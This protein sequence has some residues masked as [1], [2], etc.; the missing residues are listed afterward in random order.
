MLV[1]SGQMIYFFFFFF[2]TEGLR[3][4]NNDKFYKESPVDLTDVHVAQINSVV[5]EMFN[6]KEISKKCNQYLLNYDIRPARFYTLPK[7]HEGVFPPP[8]RPIISGN[9]FP[10]ERIS[11]F[12][13][14]F[15]KNISCKGK[16]FIKD[17]SDFLR[18][19]EGIKTAPK[20]SFLVTLD[21]VSLYPNIPIADSISAC[22]AGLNTYRPVGNEQRNSSILRLLKLVMISNH[23]TF[24][25]KNYLQISGTATGTK[26]APNVAITFMN[27][28]E[29]NFVFNYALDLFFWKRFIDDCFLIWTHSIF[30]LVTFVDYLNSRV[31]TIKFTFEASLSEVNFLDTT[32]HL[33]TNVDLWTDFYCKPTD[34][35]SYLRFDSSHPGHCCKSLPYSQFLRVRRICSHDTDYDKHG[36]NMISYFVERGYPKQLL[37]DT[38]NQV[39]G[40]TRESLLEIK[41]LGTEG[42]Q[43]QKAED[44][45]FAISTFHPTYRDFKGVITDNWDLLAAP[46]T[47]SLYESK[48]IYGNRR[49]KNLRDMLVS[50][51][52]KF[53]SSMQGTGVP[54]T[55]VKAQKTCP[56][57]N[58]CKYCPV[59]DL[60][61]QIWGLHDNRSWRTR[62]NANCQSNNCIYAIECTRCNQHYVGQTSRHVGRR[63]YEHRT[64]ILE[65][66]LELSVGE[67]FSQEK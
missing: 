9:G 28:F 22:A 66:N 39:K 53:D 21:V 60:S 55:N 43:Q 7:I 32:V 58:T 67:H 1:S 37:L 40:F 24:C 12:V 38:F 56:R 59:L 61:G 35:H 11:Q 48:V 25:G 41:N 31:E 45:V 8:G 6:N 63:M 49:P 36:R 14:F 20:G 54:R 30:E 50:A 34:S 3:Q 23:F 57:K 10:T 42:S 47:K 29:D 17:T 52:V 62:V 18:M 4:L 13:D 64:S 46:S 16:S 19:I 5:T 33:E 27:R 51:E 26:A 15:I 44:T 65:E 2:L